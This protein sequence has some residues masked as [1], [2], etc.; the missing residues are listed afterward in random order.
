[1]KA[2]FL[3]ILTNGYSA[4]HRSDAGSREWREVEER[5]VEAG[6]IERRFDE[7][8][9]ISLIETTDHGDNLME[10]LSVAAV[11]YLKMER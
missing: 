4:K 2:M 1:M 8:R 5:M 10:V 9:G 3:D 11:E 6:L 7:D